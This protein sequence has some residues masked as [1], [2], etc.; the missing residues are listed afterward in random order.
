MI[1][2]GD[3]I[4]YID[5]CQEEGVNLQRGMNFRLHGKFGVI[6]MSPLPNAPYAERIEENGKLLIY[7][8]E[9]PKN[10]RMP[11]PKIIDQTMKNP[12]RTLTQNGLFYSAAT[13]FTK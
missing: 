1:K 3:V 4:S 10:D 5:M 12:N 11:N 6:L 2:P 9:V 13:A 7:G 8:H